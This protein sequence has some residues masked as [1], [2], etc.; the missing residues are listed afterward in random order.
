[1]EPSVPPVPIARVE[2]SVP[3][4]VKLFWTVKVFSDVTENPVTV[5]AFPVIEPV[6]VPMFGVVNTGELV[7]ATTVP[8]PLVV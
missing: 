4:K 6:A 5:A 8:E 3:L 1:L 2:P 7:K